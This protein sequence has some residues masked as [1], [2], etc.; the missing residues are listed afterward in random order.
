M[1]FSEENMFYLFLFDKIYFSGEITLKK[2]YLYFILIDIVN[3]FRNKAFLR[4][5]CEI[6]VV[7]F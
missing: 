5:M 4:K 1:F 7:E 3:Y 6:K 2:R